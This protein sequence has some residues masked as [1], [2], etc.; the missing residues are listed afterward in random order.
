MSTPKI[1]VVIPVYNE[2]ASLPELNDELRSALEKQG[3]N[4]EIIFV[5]DGSTDHTLAQLQEI[6]KKDRRVKWI[7]L[8]SNFGKSAAISAG[9]KAA[10]GD[11]VVTLDGDLQDDPSEIP[12]LIRELDKGFDIVSGWKLHRRDPWVKILLSKIYNFST[13]LVTGIRLHDFNCGLKAYRKQVLEEVSVYGELHRYIPVLAAWRGFRVSEI[14]VRH[15]PRKYGRSKYG[16]ARLLSGLLDLF[17]V[18]F[19]TRF[20]KKPAHFFGTIGLLLASAGFTI[21]C[22]IFYLRIQFGNIQSRY[23]LLFLGVLLTIVGVQFLFTGLLAELITFG[24]KK[25]EAEYTIRNQ[26]S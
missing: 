13:A 12:N 21:N 10:S 19:L 15:R 26:S 24:Q 16:Y 9:F 23:P 20:T 1:S 22:Y 18:M 7:Q 8:R 6:Q 17:T 25:S 5:D 14:Q 3:M 11:V 2:S 4:F